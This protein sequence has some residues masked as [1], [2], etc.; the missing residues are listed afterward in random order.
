MVNRNQGGYRDRCR[1][2]ECLRSSFILDDTNCSDRPEVP[3]KI[4]EEGR[5][6]AVCGRARS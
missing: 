2:T 6:R 5:P 4:G 3:E 1:H